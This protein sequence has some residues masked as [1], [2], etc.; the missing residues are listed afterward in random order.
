MGQRQTRSIRVEDVEW[1]GTQAQLLQQG[2]FV[3]VFERENGQ[4]V[5]S[6][7]Q[8]QN[9]ADELHSEIEPGAEMSDSIVQ[10]FADISGRVPYVE[11]QHHK[12]RHKTGDLM[13]S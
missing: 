3:E 1:N 12:H 11:V 13:I 10:M 7:E 4:R 6:F 2:S 8:T 5:E 9:L